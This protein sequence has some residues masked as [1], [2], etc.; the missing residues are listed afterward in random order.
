MAE[1]DLYS[2]FTIEERGKGNLCAVFHLS[3]P[4]LTDEI[5]KYNYNDALNE[6]SLVDRVATL[7][8]SL[9]RAISA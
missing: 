4:S 3:T 9:P 5:C 1:K 2:D 6:T 7:G 8:R